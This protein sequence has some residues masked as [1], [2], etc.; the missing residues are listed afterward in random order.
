M[1]GFGTSVFVGRRRLVVFFSPRTSMIIVFGLKFGPTKSDTWVRFAF[2]VVRISF[3]LSRVLTGPSTVEFRVWGPFPTFLNVYVKN[4]RF[5]RDKKKTVVSLLFK[6]VY[7]PY[8][9]RGLTEIRY[10]FRQLIVTQIRFDVILKVWTR[11][12]SRRVLSRPQVFFKTNTHYNR[13]IVVN[14]CCS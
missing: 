9:V 3:S 13:T 10:F 5:E 2:P 4:N 8:F 12:L 14:Y 7:W 6:N 1:V 11:N